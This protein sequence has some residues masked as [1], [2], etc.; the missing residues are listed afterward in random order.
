MPNDTRHPRTDDRV[1]G[2]GRR[3]AETAF[4]VTPIDR[5]GSGTR[6]VVAVVVV[7]LMIVGINLLPS[8]GKIEEQPRATVG[9]VPPSRT[10]ATPSPRVAERGRSAAVHHVLGWPGGMLE[11][12]IPAGWTWST[13]VPLTVVTGDLRGPDVSVSFDQDIAAV[14][15]GICVGTSDFIDA[16]QTVDDLVQALAR[17]TG[18]ESTRVAR[19]AIDGHQATRYSLT[20]PSPCPEPAEGITLWRT[21]DGADYTPIEGGFVV[22]YVMDVDGHRLVVTTDGRGASPEQLDD[23]GR[24]IDSL[25]ITAADQAFPRFDP[26]ARRQLGFVDGIELSIRGPGPGWESHGPYL[27]TSVVGP[28]GAE[29]AIL[30]T[31]FPDGSRTTPCHALIG[32][33]GPSADDLADALAT[34]PGTELVSG[35]TNAT[36]GGLPA[37]RLTVT[38][39]ALVREACQPGFYFSWPGTQ[40]GAF[41]GATEAGDAITVWVVAVADARLVIEVLA[42]P[43]IDEPTRSAIGLVVDS[44]SF[45]GPDTPAPS[46]MGPA[47]MAYQQQVLAICRAATVRWMDEIGVSGIAARSLAEIA[48]DAA[49]TVRMADDST[50]ALR[51]LPIPGDDR[52]RVAR[53]IDLLGWAIDA[54]REIPAAARAGDMLR[55]ERLERERIVRTHQKDTLV[56][57]YFEGCPLGLPA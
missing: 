27:S 40:G 47:M 54:L 50:A 4:A 6:H 39:A 2:I 52:E 8:F 34:A 9:T 22:I 11:V 45:E 57:S 30:L 53:Q 7:A 20:L 36:I 17:Q 14:R 25:R 10:A 56:D 33:V 19:V 29:A 1:E 32:P 5:E 55:V 23:R 21:A 43:D 44:L 35:P 18:A 41:W 26:Q 16:G 46:P 38:V 13:D 48:D 37:V 28:Q 3:P 42:H 51:A 49:A 15:T 31:T 12:D 24:I